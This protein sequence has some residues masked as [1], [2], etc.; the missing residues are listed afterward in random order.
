MGEVYFDDSTDWD[1]GLSMYDDDGDGWAK[2]AIILKTQVTDTVARW[3][4][5]AVQRVAQ[6][7]AT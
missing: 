1:D 2:Y 6:L 5:D 4:I 3:I 7:V